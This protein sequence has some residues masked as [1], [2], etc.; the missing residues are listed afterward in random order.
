M[1]RNDRYIFRE[2]PARCE[3]DTTSISPKVTRFKLGGKRSSR[4]RN[5]HSAIY[6]APRLRDLS[7]RRRPILNVEQRRSRRKYPRCA[8][9]ISIMHVRSA[10]LVHTSDVSRIDVSE[11]LTFR[12]LLRTST[13]STV[14]PTI[15]PRHSTRSLPFSLSPSH[16]LP[17]IR[18][19]QVT[20]IQTAA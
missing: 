9:R 6:L 11:R 5:V 4:E 14:H 10:F 17:L 2:L 8:K 7:Q 19:V 15:P 3:R 20:F 13:C 18:P 16:S 12:P 1:G